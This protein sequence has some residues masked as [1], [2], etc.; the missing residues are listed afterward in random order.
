MALTLSRVMERVWRK[1]G[2]MTD[3]TATGGSTTTVIDTLTVAQKFTA[4]DMMIGGTAIV[5]YDAG[6]AGAAPEGEFKRISD[7]VAST[8]TFTT[9][10][11]SAAVAA[12]DRIGIAKP[13]IW[14]Q[15]M[16]ELVNDG[17]INLGTISLVDISLTA[18][19]NKTEYA[20][21]VELKI[22]RLLDIEYNR[23]TTDSDNNRWRSIISQSRYVPSAPA[24]T[25]LLILPQLPEGRTIKITYEGVHPTLTAFNSTVSE[26]IQE[27]LAVAAAVDE[28]LTWLNSKKNGL[29]DFLKQ[30]WNDAKQTL[31]M[32]KAEKPVFRSKPKPRWLVAGGNSD[33]DEFRPIPLP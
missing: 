1:L 29:D 7:Y 17:L 16:Q 3:I 6:G 31:Q 27:E 4:D 11:F 30:R 9:E 26:T 15:Q 33:T 23:I 19:A 22:E 32:Q 14:H 25:G 21:P 8:A 20:L 18:A 2:H 12:G 24:S 13:T 28:V 10:A 5:T